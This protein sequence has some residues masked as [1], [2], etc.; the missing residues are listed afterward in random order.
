M[1]TIRKMV[2]EV[3][4]LFES[5]KLAAY[6]L[7]QETR[8]ENALDLWYCAEDIAWFLERHH[9]TDLQSLMEMRKKHKRDLGYIEF[10]RHIAYR[11]HIFTNEEDSL[12]NW[13]AGER[14]LANPEW[15]QAIVQV[16]VAYGRSKDNPEALNDVRS[17]RVRSYYDGIGK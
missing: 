11:V 16:A 9:M 8:H 6:F 7:W 17:E 1:R 10:M 13:Y 4:N 12:T 3:E 15:C 5:T 2:N 14:L